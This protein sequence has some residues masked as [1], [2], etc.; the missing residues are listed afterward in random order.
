M[1]FTGDDDFLIPKSLEKCVSFLENN[2]EYGIVQGNGIIYEMEGESVFGL[3]KSL[4]CY[5]LKDNE[6]ESPKE[7]FNLFLS[8]YW[9]PEFSV[10]LTKN[11]ILACKSR[12]DIQNSGFA[13]ILTSCLSI[14]QGKSKKV[15][16]KL[17][18]EFLYT[19]SE[20]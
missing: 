1:V 3:I 20:I 14:I 15:K 17:R 12:N 9:V 16:I 8:N 2:P 10:R 7:R 18:W 19:F 5:E 6:Y 11:H 13:E 4:G